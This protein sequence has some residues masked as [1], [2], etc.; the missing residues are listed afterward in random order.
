MGKDENA[1]VALYKEYRETCKSITATNTR[2]HS[3]IELNDKKAY[4]DCSA[5]V[6]E[7]KEWQRLLTLSCTSIDSHISMRDAVGIHVYADTATDILSSDSVADLLIQ[8]VCCRS[9][10]QISD[11]NA[12]FFIKYNNDMQTYITNQMNKSDFS[13]FIYYVIAGSTHIGPNTTFTI[14]YP[15]NVVLNVDLIHES[16]NVSKMNGLLCVLVYWLGLYP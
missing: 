16:L 5:A 7:L 9:R 3:E 11:A 10:K 2:I 8:I 4:F 14:A 13:K 12:Q 6:A 15:G 1:L